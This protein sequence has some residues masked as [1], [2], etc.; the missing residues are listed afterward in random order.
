MHLQPQCQ[1]SSKS[2]FFSCLKTFYFFIV[3]LSRH[4]AEH[5]ITVHMQFPQKFAKDRNKNNILFPFGG[6]TNQD[7]L[8]MSIK[9]IWT[10]TDSNGLKSGIFYWLRKIL[11][12]VFIPLSLTY[13]LRRFLSI[14]ASLLHVCR[15]NLS[16]ECE[17]YHFLWGQSGDYPALVHRCSEARSAMPA[18]PRRTMLFCRCQSWDR[19][20]DAVPSWHTPAICEKYWWN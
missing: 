12:V 8:H 16:R 17:T 10:K 14:F 7:H 15:C 4:K 2:Q 9:T 3:T 6:K 13:F 18:P 19:V 11:E 5:L 1:Q 20:F